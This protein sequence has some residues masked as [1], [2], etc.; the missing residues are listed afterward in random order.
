MKL[1]IQSNTLRLRLSRSDVAALWVAGAVAESTVFPNGQTLTY[2]VESG[3]DGFAAE[4]T[5]HA[6]RICIAKDVVAR[7]AD[8][9][10]EGMYGESGALKVSV[11]KDFECLTRRGEESEVDTFPNPAAC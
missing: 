5:Q 7:W 10:D 4:F 2:S 3:G 6:I 9:E 1:R 11:E 8:G